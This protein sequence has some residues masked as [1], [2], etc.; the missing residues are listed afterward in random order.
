MDG[1]TLS[2]MVSRKISSGIHTQEEDQMTCMEHTL[3]YENKDAIININTD[4]GANLNFHPDMKFTTPYINVDDSIPFNL[5]IGKKL[6]RI[7]TDRFG[8]PQL[9]EVV[10]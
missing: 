3:T 2:H 9:C 1:R 5:L 8:E 4:E 7:I 6:Y 10:E